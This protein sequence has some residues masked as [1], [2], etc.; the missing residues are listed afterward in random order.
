MTAS[1]RQSVHVVIRRAADGDGGE[2]ARLWLRARRASIPAIPPPVHSDD[3]VTGWFRDVVLLQR[4]VWLA[5]RDD[6]RQI[7]GLMVLDCEWVDQLYVEPDHLG[8][9]IGS[10]LLDV[11]KARRPD[12]L[13]LW[14][15]QS[16]AGARRFYERHGF[17]EVGR[18]DGDNEEGAPDIR[19]AWVP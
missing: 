9:G 15:F 2:I 1:Q 8:R 10:Q 19:Y 5:C 17:S 3:E 6:D 18:T 14:T 13:Q 16:N 7:L 12:G 4:E 11:A